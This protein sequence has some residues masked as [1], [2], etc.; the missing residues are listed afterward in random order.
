M[1]NGCRNT[2]LLSLLVAVLSLAVTASAG[3]LSLSA[4]TPNVSVSARPAGRNFMRLPSLRYEFVV[5]SHCPEGLSPETLSLSIADTRVTRNQ[6]DIAY[7]A[8]SLSVD[9]PASQIGPVAVEQFCTV[10]SIDQKGSQ[11]LRLS[12]VLSA[13]SSLLCVGDAGNDMTYTSASLDVVLQCEDD[14][15]AEIEPL[16]RR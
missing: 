10:E 6:E 8:T 4:S 16:P 2:L 5:E 12:S 1:K 13:Q 3:E 15:E 9:V 11:S 14:E 7:A